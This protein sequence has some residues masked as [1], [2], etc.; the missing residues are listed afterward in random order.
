MAVT[1]QCRGFTWCRSKSRLP[2]RRT[3]AC[4]P[5]A[6]WTLETANDER[7]QPPSVAVLQKKRTA[8]VHA[9]KYQQS[10]KQ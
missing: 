9:A 4:D 5:G 6:R 3:E 1:L 2:I 10:G 7:A 8:P